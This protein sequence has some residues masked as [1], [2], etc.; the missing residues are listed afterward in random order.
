MALSLW[1][2]RFYPWSG[3]HLAWHNAAKYQKKKKKKTRFSTN[4]KGREKERIP[5][6][7]EFDLVN[8]KI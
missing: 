2:P 5:K 8:F 3:N 4:S 1:R 7:F 6:S